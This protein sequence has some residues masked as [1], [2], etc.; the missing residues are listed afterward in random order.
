MAFNV[1]DDDLIAETQM[2][3]VEIVEVS[4]SKIDRLERKIDDQA[5]KLD[6]QARKLDEQ[7]R[8]IAACTNQLA[9]L[10]ALLEVFVKGKAS[11]NAVNME[12]PIATD[13]ALAALE[14]ALGRGMKE[15]CTSAVTNLLKRGALTK[16]LKYIFVE[17]LI[18]NYNIDGV[19][20]SISMVDPGKPPEKWLGHAL[21]A[22][23]NN[24]SLTVPQ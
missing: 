12:F 21:T 20:D 7:A 13:E 4:D 6:E 17:D 3:E 14:F 10:T 18:V 9:K 22:I 1:D 19:S 24:K 2:S 15:E 11:S 16:S 23:K 8:E 5:R